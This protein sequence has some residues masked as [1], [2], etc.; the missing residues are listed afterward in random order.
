MEAPMPTCAGC[1]CFRADVR[2]VAT[3]EGPQSLCWLC[4]HAVVEHGIR[5]TRIRC[6]G[7]TPERAVYRDAEGSVR[8]RLDEDHVC[9]HTRAAIYPADVI[10]YRDDFAEAARSGCKSSITIV[11]SGK[12]PASSHAS[13]ELST[14]F[15]ISELSRPRMAGSNLV[16]LN[17][18]S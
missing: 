10:R 12:I 3:D 16:N 7:V 6:G 14:A 18:E 1:G 11:T 4:R 8:M 13:S 2:D 5:L 15:D 9:L 17:P